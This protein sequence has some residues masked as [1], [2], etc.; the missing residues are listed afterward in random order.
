MEQEEL[1]EFELME[2]LADESSFSSQC[3]LV[4]KM[5]T[6]GGSQQSGEHRTVSQRDIHRMDDSLPPNESQNVTLTDD[7]TQD[8]DTIS[9]LSDVQSIGS[10][11]QHNGGFMSAGRLSSHA[12]GV[13]FDDEDTWEEGRPQIN[14]GAGPITSTP[15]VKTI[16]AR[17][18]KVYRPSKQYSLDRYESS[19]Q[20]EGSAVQY[21]KRENFSEQQRSG[22]VKPVE[23]SHSS[24]VDDDDADSTLVSETTHPGIEPEIPV[25]TNSEHNSP[26][27]VLRPELTSPPPMSALVSKLF[28]S[29]GSN[30]SQ[31]KHSLQQSPVKAAK[32]VSVVRESGLTRSDEVSAVAVKQKLVELET[33]IERFKRENL[34]VAKLKE[35][36]EKVELIK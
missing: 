20:A 27:S 13:E 32:P 5:M 14:A 28:P 19:D 11:Q 2:Q 21:N 30:R 8:D 3:S 36:R 7:E 10:D 22:F 16:I 6:K 12:I 31:Q 34:A 25:K 17:Q 4:R 35:E 26:G 18:R 33:E 24:S 23:V 1:E 9:T 15:P 29:L